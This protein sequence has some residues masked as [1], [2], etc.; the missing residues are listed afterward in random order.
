MTSRKK[1]NISTKDNIVDDKQN[2]RVNFRKTSNG[3]PEQR[4]IRVQFK[5]K[6]RFSTC[7]N[8]EFL[9]F[10]RQTFSYC[11]FRFLTFVKLVE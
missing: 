2:Y 9:F 11:R 8:S 5:L 1:G 3:Q 4:K 7:G 6:F 10:T